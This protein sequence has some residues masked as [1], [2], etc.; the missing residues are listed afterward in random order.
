MV[1]VAEGQTRGPQPAPIAADPDAKIVNLR[2][3][4]KRR[5]GRYASAMEIYLSGGES[6]VRVSHGFRQAGR[7]IQIESFGDVAV[8]AECYRRGTF[9]LIP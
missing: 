8:L 9:V 7:E 3:T 4:G 6:L 5:S 1:Q 2:A